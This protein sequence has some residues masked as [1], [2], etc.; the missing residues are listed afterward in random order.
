MPRV[1][2]TPPYHQHYGWIPG[3]SGAVPFFSTEE[4]DKDNKINK[5]PSPQRTRVVF[6][7]AKEKE[8]ICIM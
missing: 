3:A 5:S 8:G 7:Q 6:I 2:A 4:Q 1:G